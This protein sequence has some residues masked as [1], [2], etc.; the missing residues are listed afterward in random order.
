MN[1]DPIVMEVRK[2]R[3][4]L[5][6]KFAYDIDAIVDDLQRREKEMEGPFVTRPPRPPKPKYHTLARG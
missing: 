3:D 5:A 1:D 2:L 4:Q 6:A